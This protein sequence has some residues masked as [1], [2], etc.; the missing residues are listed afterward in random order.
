MDKYPESVKQLY[1]A[2]MEIANHSDTHPH[3]SK[4]SDKEIMN[5]VSLCNEKIEAITGEPVKLFRCPYGEYDDN[6]IS[7][8]NG[9]GINVIQWNVDS[10]DW[11]DLSAEDIYTRVTRDVVPG[12]IVLFHN[13][14]LH[15]PEALADI[16]EY[17][18]SEGYE[19]VPVSELLLT[20]EY[21]ID[22]AGMMVAKET[23]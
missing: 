4:L 1:D 22:H 16:I 12:S 10:L 13:A 11:K 2:G 19:I 23:A 15:T 9:M 18:L 7:T 20:G 14:A 3:M 6:V 8:I 17:L 21:E 5:E